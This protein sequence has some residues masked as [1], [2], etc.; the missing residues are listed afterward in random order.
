MNYP[1]DQWILISSTR[2]E[3]HVSSW[4]S[5]Q[6]KS[7]QQ[8]QRGQWLSWEQYSQELIKIFAPLDE[9]EGAR[10]QLKELK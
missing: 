1:R 4:F 8:G 5:A 10:R 7:I 2:L 3:G 6:I 9:E